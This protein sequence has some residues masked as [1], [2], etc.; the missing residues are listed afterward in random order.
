MLMPDCAIPAH[1]P[2]YVLG[3]YS[4]YTGYSIENIELFRNRRVRVAGYSGYK[5]GRC[6][7]S[8][9]LS[10]YGITKYFQRCNR[11]N[12]CNRKKHRWVHVREMQR[13]RSG[14][15]NTVKTMPW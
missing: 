5:K 1:A 4:G 6:N 12:R 8:A 3:G 15:K 7:R 10:G 14:E 2:I 11:C 9:D 13:G